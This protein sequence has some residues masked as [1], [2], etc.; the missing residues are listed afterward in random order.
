MD[1]TT[2]TLIAPT[3]AQW[4]KSST[5]ERVVHHMPIDTPQWQARSQELS[6]WYASVCPPWRESDPIPRYQ[7]EE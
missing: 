2:P 1:T 5:C 7:E 3:Y 6:E 4:I